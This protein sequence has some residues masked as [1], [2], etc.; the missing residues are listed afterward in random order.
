MHTLT[1]TAD[2]E[3]QIVVT[4]V[5]DAPRHLVWDAHTRPELVKRW[6]AGPAGWTMEVCVIDLR[7]GGAYRYVWRRDD[8]GTK[9]GVGGVYRE[10]VAPERM[11]TT[12]RFDQSWYDGEGVGTLVLHERDGQTTLTNTLRYDTR[13]IR[14]RVLAS[15]MDQGMAASYDR[16]ERMLHEL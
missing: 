9:M 11:V 15:P 2:G 1:I 10:V 14:D 13:E 8:T 3:H 6:L 12:E 4:R 16:L 7:V 5:F